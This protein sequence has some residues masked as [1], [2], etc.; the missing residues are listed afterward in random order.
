LTKIAKG[1]HIPSKF[2]LEY[3]AD[4]MTIA[5]EQPILIEA[6]GEVLGSTPATFDV[7]ADAIP[8][9]I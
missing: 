7:V 6:D 8:L 4:S 3:L 2:V 1:T 9:K 5:S